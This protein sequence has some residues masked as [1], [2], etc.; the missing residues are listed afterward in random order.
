MPGSSVPGISQAR[1]LQWVAISFSRRSFPPKDQTWVSRTAGRFFT[2]WAPKETPSP[3]PSLN[4]ICKSVFSDSQSHVPGGRVFWGP[5][6]GPAHQQDWPWAKQPACPAHLGSCQAQGSCGPGSLDLI[7]QLQSPVYGLGFR[8]GGPASALDS[9]LPTLGG[10]RC[11]SCPGSG[12]HQLAGSRPR[13]GSAFGQV[14][15]FYAASRQGQGSRQSTPPP[16]SPICKAS[17]SC[18]VKGSLWRGSL[19]VYKITPVGAQLHE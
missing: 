12:C 15:L 6:F 1:I 11:T 8:K 9:G 16:S 7:D 3:G 14:T 18:G 10:R 17:C 19:A 2:S 5:P 4:S 13:P